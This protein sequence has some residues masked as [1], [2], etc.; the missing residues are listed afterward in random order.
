MSGLGA[1]LGTSFHAHVER[2]LAAPV[3]SV[4]TLY[5]IRARL[6]DIDPLITNAKWDSVRTVLAQHPV[7]DAKEVCEKMLKE[8]QEDL[9]GVIVGL[10]EDMLSAIRLLDTSVYANVFVGEDREILGTKVDYDV[11][12]VYLA[13]LKDAVDALIQVAEE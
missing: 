1:F 12:R 4:D 3:P 11:P 7:R 10:R 2:A 13:D 8:N 6:N 9:R 5:A